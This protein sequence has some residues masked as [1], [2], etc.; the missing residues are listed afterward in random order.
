MAESLSKQG[1]FPNIIV[2]LDDIFRVN[3][4]SGFSSR[5]VNCVDLLT[6]TQT[7]L[8]RFYSGPCLLVC[9]LS[10]LPVFIVDFYDIFSS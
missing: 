3:S 1:V 2:N 5:L 7:F 8:V 9:N 4:F 6:C 10:F